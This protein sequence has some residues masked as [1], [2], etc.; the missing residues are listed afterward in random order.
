MEHFALCTWEQT[1]ESNS[2][3]RAWPDE[4]SPL[5]AGTLVLV[6]PPARKSS[7]QSYF[8]GRAGLHSCL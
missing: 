6:S 8:S 4:E 1:V 2:C 3:P 7:H 5:E